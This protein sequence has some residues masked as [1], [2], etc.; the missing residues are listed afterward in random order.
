M[1]GPTE[2]NTD[3]RRLVRSDPDRARPAGR[4]GRFPVAFHK[5]SLV[6]SLDRN[7][8]STCLEPDA[9][10]NSVEP[11]HRH[12][13]MKGNNF[14]ESGSSPCTEPPIQIRHVAVNQLK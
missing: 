10:V 13:I 3:L 9:A 11:A 7:S 5:S 1:S 6:A 8:S 2:V 12:V 14:K 4:G